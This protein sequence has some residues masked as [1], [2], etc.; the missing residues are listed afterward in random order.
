[1]SSITI[2]GKTYS[3]N[4]ISVRND[5]VYIDGKIADQAKAKD[6]I[7]EVH[8]EGTLCNVKSDVSVT[9]NGNVSGNVES[10]NYVKC[11]VVGGNVSAGNYIKC[12]NVTGSATAG[13]YI[14]RS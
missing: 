11:E 14:S 8:V 9:V 13:N 10:G 12:G 1:M 3:G 6:G 2:N 4:N 5:V 7:L